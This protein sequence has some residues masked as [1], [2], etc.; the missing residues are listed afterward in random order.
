MQLRRVDHEE[1]SCD[2]EQELPDRQ[3]QNYEYGFPYGEH[4]PP[5]PVRTL[6][7][8]FHEP[9]RAGTCGAALISFPKKLS[10]E[11]DNISWGLHAC[12]WLSFSKVMSMIFL[13]LAPTLIFALYWL[14]LHNG[15]IQNALT[16]SFLFFAFVAIYVRVSISCPAS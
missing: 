7:K 8:C 6:A 1:V 10:E 12:E 11:V 15:D 14:H 9:S 13:G 5:V 2:R 16:P 4:I 3:N